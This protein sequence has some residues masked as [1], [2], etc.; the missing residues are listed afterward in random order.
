MLYCCFIRTNRFTDI[1][2][3]RNNFIYHKPDS[4]YYYGDGSL[5]NQHHGNSPIDGINA[6]DGMNI[7]IENHAQPSILATHEIRSPLA[8]T[9]ANSLA[10]AASPTGSACT[11]SSDETNENS[12]AAIAAAAAADTMFLV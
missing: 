3:T 9:R 7:A 4:T 10:S 6:D 1:V 5:A 8:A 12:T 11:K 2:L